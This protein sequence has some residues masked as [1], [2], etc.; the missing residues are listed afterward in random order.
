MNTATLNLSASIDDFYEV[1]STTHDSPPI[2][3]AGTFTTAGLE[4]TYGNF[5]EIYDKVLLKETTVYANSAGPVVVRLLSG[6]DVLGTLISSVTA[7]V[8]PGIQ[9]IS[10]NLEMDPS[11]WGNRFTLASIVDNSTTL[12]KLRR[13]AGTINYPFIISDPLRSTIGRVVSSNVLDRYYWFYSP[14]FVKLINSYTLP[15]TGQSPVIGA[16]SDSRV[17]VSGVFGNF[18]EIDKKVLF[19]TATVSAF[20]TGTVTFQMRQGHSTAGTLISSVAVN[21]VTGIQTITL[22]LEMDPDRWGTK[23][24]IAKVNDESP[25]APQILARTPYTIDFPFAISDPIYGEVGRVTGTNVAENSRYY[26]FYSPVFEFTPNY[27]VRTASPAVLKGA[28]TVNLVL[29]G[30]T[31]KDYKV[32]IATINWGD[33]SPTETLKRDIFFNYKTNSIFNE[34]LN[35]KIGGSCLNVHSHVYVNQTDVYGIPHTL[36][37]LIQKNSGTYLNIRQPISSYWGSY[38]DNL[39]NISILNTQVLPTTGNTSFISFESN[40]GSVFAANLQ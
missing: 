37:I 33:G 15:I 39:N 17:L 22:N 2:S 20:D 21:V 16:S 6:H 26:W 1:I 9:T 28:T 27:T 30:V 8:V 34:V 32:D 23:F 35:G 25:S 14:K 36:N 13:T 7:N 12:T 31:E 4:G 19:K 18:Y 10:L 11:K 24:T 5:Y 3:G 29:T 40:D 38:Y